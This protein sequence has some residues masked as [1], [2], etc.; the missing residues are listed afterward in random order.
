LTRAGN[1][2]TVALKNAPVRQVVALDFRVRQSRGLGAVGGGRI[3]PTRLRGLPGRGG[4]F[5]SPSKMEK[6]F[7]VQHSTPNNQ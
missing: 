2:P 3:E 6:T 4:D 7:N 5:F 1:P